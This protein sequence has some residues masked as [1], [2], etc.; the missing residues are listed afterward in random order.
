MDERWSV[1][2]V[3]GGREGGVRYEV[4]DG[5]ESTRCFKRKTGRG[6]EAG[7]GTGTGLHRT[8]PQTLAKKPARSR[9]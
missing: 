4:V 9:R 6:R 5:K 2:T 3:T 8:S 7:A 1:W